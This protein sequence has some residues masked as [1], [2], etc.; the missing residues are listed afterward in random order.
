M[1]LS[2]G[3]A[4]F[5]VT[6]TRGPILH[7]SALTASIQKNTTNPPTW[8]YK[9]ANIVLDLKAFKSCLDS[10]RALKLV[11]E[12]NEAGFKAGIRGAPTLIVNGRRLINWYMLS[13]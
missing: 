10:D 11:K 1:S 2:S 4:V 9:E 3:N 8:M 5:A 7:Q 13:R 12:D 6:F